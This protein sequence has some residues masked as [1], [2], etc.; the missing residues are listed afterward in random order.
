ME[1]SGL[2][3]LFVSKPRIW[4]PAP[5]PFSF[6][7]W[8]SFEITWGGK[9]GDPTTYLCDLDAWF[10]SSVGPHGMEVPGYRAIN[11]NLG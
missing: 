8:P 5:W 7:T 4:N 2:R 1:L 9:N 11:V 3:P 6:E 10:S